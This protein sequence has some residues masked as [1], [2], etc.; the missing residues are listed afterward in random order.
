MVVTVVT[1]FS[2]THTRAGAS[3]HAYFVLS[4]YMLVLV[5][6]KTL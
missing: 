2:R 6:V 3:G 4:I 1:V 5:Y